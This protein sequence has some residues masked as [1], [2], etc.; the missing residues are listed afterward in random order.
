MITIPGWLVADA[1]W[2]AVGMSFRCPQYCAGTPECV[3]ER[4]SVDDARK[5]Y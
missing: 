2:I 3:I 4:E 1:I 5:V